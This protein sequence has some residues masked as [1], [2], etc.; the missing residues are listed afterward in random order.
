MEPDAAVSRAFAGEL[1]DVTADAVDAI[2]A[3]T[4]LL[5]GSR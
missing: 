2:F 5:T 4:R 3:A 1:A